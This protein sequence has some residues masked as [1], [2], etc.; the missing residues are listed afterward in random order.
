LNSDKK[1]IVLA[2][3]NGAGKTT[4]AKSFLPNE[5]ACTTFI[6]ADLIAAGIAPFAPE[7]AAIAAG[8]LMLEMVQKQV[9]SG[10]SFALETT[11]SGMGYARMIPQWRALGYT[12]ELFFLSLPRVDYAVERV[13]KRVAQGG[14]FIPENVIRRRFEAGLYNFHNIYK[15]LVDAWS[16][17]DSS[18]E[19]IK[20]INWSE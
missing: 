18:Q 20:V 3:P 4:F 10:N 5:A 17:M 13:A 11:L 15:P 12:V 7:S 8:R 9:A 14:H 19:P 1:I 16:L 6:N 2:G